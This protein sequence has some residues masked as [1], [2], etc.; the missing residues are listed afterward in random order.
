MELDELALLKEEIRGLDKSIATQSDTH[1]N[2]VANKMAL[3]SELDNLRKKE[4]DLKQFLLE[5]CVGGSNALLQDVDKLKET[6]ENRKTDLRSR[7]AR[8]ARL[9]Q[10]KDR[11]SAEVRGIQNLVEELEGIHAG[12][13]GTHSSLLEGV[14]KA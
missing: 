4:K 8:N 13:Q 9:Q 11:Y 7:E 1:H 3:K 12:L 6:I 10:E 14:R 5:H 2:L